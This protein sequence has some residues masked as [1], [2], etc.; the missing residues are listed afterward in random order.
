MILLFQYLVVL[1]FDDEL[2]QFID[3]RPDSTSIIPSGRITWGPEGA[4]PPYPIGQAYVANSL[5]WGTGGRF[6]PAHSPIW[7]FNTECE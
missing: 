3:L 5:A 7:L 4:W 1:H 6:W 2:V